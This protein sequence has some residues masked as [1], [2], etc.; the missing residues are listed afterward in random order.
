MNK[1]IFQLLSCEIV[2]NSLWNEKLTSPLSPQSTE[3][4]R[5]NTSSNPQ[6]CGLLSS[7]L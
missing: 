7:D 4:S 5:N 6:M 1:Y 3:V 2:F